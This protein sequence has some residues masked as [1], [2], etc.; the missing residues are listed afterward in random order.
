MPKKR[1]NFRDWM[2]TWYNSTSTSRQKK[3]FK[4]VKTFVSISVEFQHPTSWAFSNTLITN[5]A[6][7]IFWSTLAGSKFG[8]SHRFVCVLSGITENGN[9]MLPSD[10]NKRHFREICMNSHL[11]NRS[12]RKPFFVLFFIVFSVVF[13][14]FICIRSVL[15]LLCIKDIRKGSSTCEFKGWVLSDRLGE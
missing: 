6:F 8:Q 5:Y 2:D 14:P 15:S 9:R 1:N 3:I 13:C 10:R 12:N 7:R 11:C 4:Y